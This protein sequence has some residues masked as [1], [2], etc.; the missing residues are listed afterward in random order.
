MN[1]LNMFEKYRFHNKLRFILW[2]IVKVRAENKSDV[3]QK[4]RLFKKLKQN[5]TQQD[6]EDTLKIIENQEEF[7][8]GVNSW[9][10]SSISVG[11]ALGDVGKLNDNGKIIIDLFIR[12]QSLLR[13]LLLIIH[14]QK[15]ALLESAEISGKIN[16]Y[17][18]YFKDEL[19]VYKEFEALAVDIP[20]E[21]FDELSIETL[22]REPFPTLEEYV[23]PLLTVMIMYAAVGAIN[24][25]LVEDSFNHIEGVLINLGIIGS[26]L[27]IVNRIVR[28]VRVILK[29]RRI[30]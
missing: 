24:P 15:S 5:P 14:S 11:N 20:K 1:L 26:G 28:R 30:S 4:L 13:N 10:V 22:K 29:I 19:K 23:I 7:L 12:G 18:S 3:K 6:I 17:K 8:R 16:K 9:I 21:V 25:K 2:Y 27:Y